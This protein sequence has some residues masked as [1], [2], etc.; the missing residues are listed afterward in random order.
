[1]I[2]HNQLTLA[3]I[4]TDCQK[5][6]EEDKPEFLKL[7]EQH[8]NINDYI[9]PSFRKRFYSRT[10][11]NRQYPL[12]AFVWALLIQKIFSVPTDTLLLLMLRYS[13]PLRDFCGFIKVPDASKITRFKQNFV[14]DL[15]SVR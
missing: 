6:F 4:F 2:P 10:G 8:I 7:L 3:D 5:I 11:R 15:K 14:S 13:K 9:P 12:S 1:M